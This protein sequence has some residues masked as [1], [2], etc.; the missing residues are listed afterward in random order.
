M[1]NFISAVGF[2]IKLLY[3]SE[4]GGLSDLIK[5]QQQWRKLTVV[6]LELGWNNHSTSQRHPDQPNR[7]PEVEPLTNSLHA[8][9]GTKSSHSA[10]CNW[11][12]SPKKLNSPGGEPG[13]W[14]HR[15]PEADQIAI[16]ITLARVFLS[17][18]CKGS[19]VARIG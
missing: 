7:A 15:R 9:C 14:L 19:L 18:L 5:Q 11:Q 1:K 10:R 16:I 6:W 3:A 4:R 13:V 8:S 12:E 2:E 17:S